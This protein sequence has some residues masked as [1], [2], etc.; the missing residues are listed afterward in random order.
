MGI[1]TSTRTIAKLLCLLSQNENLS[2]SSR[3]KETQT[4]NNVLLNSNKTTNENMQTDA[5]EQEAVCALLFF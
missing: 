2:T 4:N 1:R 3:R 5:S